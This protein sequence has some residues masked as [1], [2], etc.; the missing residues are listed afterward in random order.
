MK[1]FVGMKKGFTLFLAMCLAA[2]SLSGC[3]SSSGD[4]A[5]VPEKVF[6]DEIVTESV[7]V[8]SVTEEKV[9]S[10]NLISG[11]AL[12]S[13]IQDNFAA[14]S[15]DENYSKGQYHLAEDYVFEFPCSFEAGMIA[16]RAFEVYATAD[17]ESTHR[18]YNWNTYE[19]GVIKVAPYG[20]VQLGAD[21]SKD[22]HNGTWGSL[23]QLYLV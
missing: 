19:D 10:E 16:F 4:G 14:G 18:T 21:G 23:N 1:K 20:V 17:F 15:F 2:G 8:T 9:T 3:G 12:F 11:A 6:P 7:P 5:D 22:V 13:S